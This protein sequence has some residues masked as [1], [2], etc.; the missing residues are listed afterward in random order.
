MKKVAQIDPYLSS[1]NIIVCV[2][3]RIKTNQLKSLMKI[4]PDSVRIAGL[5]FQN[6]STSFLACSNL[7][8][9]IHQPLPDSLMAKLIGHPQFCNHKPV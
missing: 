5:R 3:T 1:A 7:F 9:F 8:R 6:D 4:E 2:T